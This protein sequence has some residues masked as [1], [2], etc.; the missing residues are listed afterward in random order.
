M[1][2]K[3]AVYIIADINEC[4]SKALNRCPH[5]CV[6]TPGSFHCECPKGYYIPERDRYKCLGESHVYT[7]SLS[8]VNL[9]CVACRII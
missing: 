6:N 3:K 2:F 4:S 1:P 8:G 7:L 5:K 9:M